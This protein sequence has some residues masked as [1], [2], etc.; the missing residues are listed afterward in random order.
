MNNTES[1]VKVYETSDYAKFKV[2]KGNRPLK[3]A[4]LKFLKESISEHGDLGTPIIV[5]ENYYVIDGQHRREALKELNL[6]V[7]YIIKKGFTLDQVHVLNTNRKN[8]SLTEFMNCYADL[9]KKH[10][11]KFK[12]FHRKYEFGISISL[13]IVQGYLGTKGGAEPFKK[14][15]FVFKHFEE[16]NERAEKITML[17]E[18]YPR[19]KNN[20][21]VLAMI[22]MFKVKGYNHMEFMSKVAKNTSRLLFFSSNDVNGWLRLFEDIYN[23][24]RHNRVSFYQEVKIRTGK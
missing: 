24:G 12:E 7:Q 20:L 3:K 19:Y 16:A 13:A 10:Y 23:S 2:L 14:G 4:H 1:V 22:R 15:E 17:K 11:V 6:P 18:M 9:G 5:N 21:F 8:W